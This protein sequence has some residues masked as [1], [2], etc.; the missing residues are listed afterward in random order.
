MENQTLEELQ[1]SYAAVCRQEKEIIDQKN[2]LKQQIES[3]LPQE[4]VTIKTADG[5]FSMVSQKKWEYSRAIKMLEEDVKI[6]KVQEQ[7]QGVATMSETFG[8]R[9][10]AN[11]VD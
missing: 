3:L 4:P 1:S 8:L 5:S 10:R 7:E 11:A 6:L 9:F 2:A